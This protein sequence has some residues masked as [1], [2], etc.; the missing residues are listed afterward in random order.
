[1]KI[2]V[3]KG[4]VNF[5]GSAIAF[6]I[7]Y[8]G[9]I[10]I[11]NSPDNLLINANS[12]RIIGFMLNGENL[13]DELFQFV[14]KLI[15]LNGKV[16]NLDESVKVYIENY[17]TDYWMAQNIE[18]GSHTGIY[19]ELSSTYSYKKVPIYNK[20]K[21]IVGEEKKHIHSTRLLGEYT[22]KLVADFIKDHTSQREFG[23][24]SI[25]GPLATSE[26]SEEIIITTNRIFENI[27]VTQLGLKWLETYREPI[28]DNK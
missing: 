16:S 13:P 22:S 10:E 2:S 6:D 5:K 14:G 3:G 8:K 9:S 24:I 26:I 20:K 25:N 28:Y 18:W 1:M 7:R 21:E 17:E 12:K 11:K 27:H 4:K 15:L 19:N 23:K